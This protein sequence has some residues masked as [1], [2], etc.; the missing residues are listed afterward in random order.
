MLLFAP[1]VVQGIDKRYY[2][3]YSV[4]HSSRMSV[5]VCDSPAG[6]FEYLGDVKTK[7]GRVY[8]ISPGDY[9]QFD[10]GVFIDDDNSVYLYSGFCP[11][12]TEDEH[13]T[14]HAG[15]FCMSSYA[16]YDDYV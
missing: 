13:G 11:K 16:R 5:A 7:D 10:P 2:L 15:C 8:G 3:Y 12:K 14:Y 6:R 9:V 4:A 1:D